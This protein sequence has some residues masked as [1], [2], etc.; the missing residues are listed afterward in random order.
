[1]HHSVR[2]LTDIDGPLVAAWL[3]GNHAAGAVPTRWNHSG[4]AKTAISSHDRYVPDR[5]GVGLRPGDHEAMQANREPP[6]DIG[7]SSPESNQ[8]PKPA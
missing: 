4:T 1:M 2:H 8:V 7:H 5:S 6:P 3:G